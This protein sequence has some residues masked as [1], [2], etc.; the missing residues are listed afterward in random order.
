MV[1]QNAVSV[2]F[3]SSGDK[4][5]TVCAQVDACWQKILSQRN[6]RLRDEWCVPYMMTD[7]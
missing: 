1:A 3:F 6:K 4:Y 2:V 5:M 7:E